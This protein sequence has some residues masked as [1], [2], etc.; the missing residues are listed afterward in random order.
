MPPK[1]RSGGSSLTQRERK[2]QAAEAKQKELEES[3]QDENSEAKKE[4]LPVIP[5]EQFLRWLGKIA[6]EHG[7]SDKFI[8]LSILAF[9]I[10]LAYFKYRDIYAEN[11]TELNLIISAICGI[12]A[13]ISAVIISHRVQSNTAMYNGSKEGIP[14][15]PWNI[16][17]LIFLPAF[18]ALTINKDLLLY[19]IALSSTLLSM[20]SPAKILVQMAILA[21]N[22]QH[23]DMV[24]NLKVTCGHLALNFILGRISEYK[25]LDKVEVNL[26]SILLTDLYLVD[27]DA[28]YVL[29]L[30]KLFI[31]FGAGLALTYFITKA[32]DQ[33]N[34]ARTIIVLL[35]WTGTFVGLTLYQLDPILG[36]NSVVWIYEY[37]TAT[38]ARL[39][40]LGIWLCSLLLLIPT[41][42]NYKIQLSPN[43]RRK[44]W[45]FLVLA[46]IVYPLHL[47]TEFVKVSLA[48]SLILFL[49]VEQTRYLK[50]YPFGALLDSHLRLFAD[51]RDDKG[52]IIVSY[53][54]LFIGISLPI[55]F[56][57][58]VVGLVVLGVGDSLASIIG[59]NYGVIFWGKSKKTMEGT[60]TFIIATFAVCS[61]LKYVGW[62]FDNKSFHAIL[63]TCTL[64]GILEGNSNLND[65]ILIPGFMSVVLE[66]VD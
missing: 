41:I 36:K 22:S 30:Q 51:F 40:I 8:Q 9:V 23:T 28:L 66:L 47:D 59:S 14:L 6:N 35:S 42:F 45:H 7:T 5:Q 24:Y 11:E 38:S 57:N 3:S 21:S 34:Y 50:L 60:M 31:S 43:F 15:P 29:I 61:L 63:L 26:F 39:Q 10:N 58:S 62:F 16:I 48:G 20:P 12:I 46:L 65:N 18:M 55:L 52:P 32:Y 56:N 1:T 33:N 19:N 17:Y 4:P 13:L 37:A 64:S 27:S 54:Y 2:R 53:I 25:S 44:I 49:I